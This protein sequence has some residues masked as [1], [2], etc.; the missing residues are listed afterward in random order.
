MRNT[1]LL[2]L[3]IGLFASASCVLGQQRTPRHLTKHQITVGDLVRTFYTFVPKS[4]PSTGKYPV[5]FVFHG[6]TGTALRM[7]RFTGFTELARREKFIVVYPQGVGRNW[8]DGRVTNK[9]RA[10]REQIDDLSFVSKMVKEIS[11]AYDVDRNM[12]FATGPSNG[13]FFS[14]YVAAHLSEDFAAIAPVIGGIAD[15]F[16]KRFN[17]KK[18]VSVFIIQGTK[19]KLVPYNGGTVGN[20]R[21]KFISTDA[22]VKLWTRHNRT[23]REPERAKLPDKIKSDQSNVETYRWKNGRKNTEVVLYK[24]VGGGHTWPGGSQYAPRR[25]VGS[26]NQDFDATEAIWEFFKSHPRK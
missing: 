4:R 19:D 8:N 13:G 21:G 10:H 18:P 17:P 20:G 23:D 9:T 26:V 7:E 16:H 14:N 1:I 2:F 11:G 15:P 25:L 22:M 24:V 12:F 3:A 5:V 6:G